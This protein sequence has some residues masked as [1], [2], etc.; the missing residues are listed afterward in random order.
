MTDSTSLLLA[1]TLATACC[2]LSA[3]P[4]SAEV[5]LSERPGNVH[6]LILTDCAK[7][8]DWQTIAAAF[9]W[10]ESGQPGKVTRIANCNEKDT[11]V[12]S[13]AMLD[14]V[15]THMAPQYAWN[16]RLKDYY[17]GVG[18]KHSHRVTGSLPAWHAAFSWCC[19]GAT[20]ACHIGEPTCA[21]IQF[22]MLHK[23]QS[24]PAY[25]PTCLTY[26]LLA[27]PAAYN[28]PGALVDWLNKTKVE[29][30]YVLLLDSDMLLR[31]PFL[32]EEFN[33]TK[34]WVRAPYYSYLKG[35][36]NEL[37]LKHIPDVA[38]RN[39]TLAGPQGRR[40]DMVGGP[41]FMRTD[42]LR[43]LAPLWLAW[44]ETMRADMEVGRGRFGWHEVLLPGGC[45]CCCL[46]SGG[47]MAC[48]LKPILA[49]SHM[50]VAFWHYLQ[51]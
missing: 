47:G 34:G 51:G 37:A 9:A 19:N 43:R 50:V 31:R 23:F 1:L 27:C 44:T 6:T 10:R 46:V 33:L 26:V 42:D 22:D 29:E 25:V 11:K 3:P 8:Q 30:E 17:A 36:H 18:K 13:K 16:E 20:D 14:V 38:P 45:M 28:K 48:A 41:Y 24:Q 2:L 32:P 40:A 49:V 5:G 12:Y 35:V 4:A 21:T 39:D 7:Y 15:H